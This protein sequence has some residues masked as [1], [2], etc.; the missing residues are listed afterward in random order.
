MERRR[1]RIALMKVVHMEITHNELAVQRLSEEKNPFET[2]YVETGYVETGYVS[3]L[4]NEAWTENRARLA[5]LEDERAVEYLGMY[6]TS[7]G[8]VL[9]T[10]RLYK[11]TD[12]ELLLIA[13][14]SDTDPGSPLLSRTWRLRYQVASVESF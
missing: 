8:T 14:C 2:G 11:E 5:R 6:Y 9:T 1:E 3:S 13:L 4:H 12:N 10:D 7:V